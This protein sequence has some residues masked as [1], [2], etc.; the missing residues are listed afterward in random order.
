MGTSSTGGGGASTFGQFQ[1]IVSPGIIVSLSCFA[2]DT[3]LDDFQTYASIGVT[4]STTITQ[5][6]RVILASGYIR[7]EHGLSWTGFYPLHDGDLIFMHLRGNLNPVFHLVERR[8]TADTQI[9]PGVTLASI[10]SAI[11]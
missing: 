4:T 5:G 8:L 7:L 10:L 3:I 1:Q 6:R 2:Q 11:K 9:I